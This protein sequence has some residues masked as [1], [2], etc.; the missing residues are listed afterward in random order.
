MLI[1][2]L[3]LIFKLFFYLDK[4]KLKNTILVINLKIKLDNTGKL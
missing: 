1:N 4:K 3:S 2:W